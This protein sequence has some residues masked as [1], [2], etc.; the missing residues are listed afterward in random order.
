M[1]E[2]CRRIWTRGVDTSLTVEC[3]TMVH[4][5]RCTAD[6]C[7]PLSQPRPVNSCLKGSASIYSRREVRQVHF[8]IRQHFS[9]PRL[10]SRTASTNPSYSPRMCTEDGQLPRRIVLVLM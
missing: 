4:S 10:P 7:L 3:L 2:K 8:L 6:A 5:I 1:A 9:L